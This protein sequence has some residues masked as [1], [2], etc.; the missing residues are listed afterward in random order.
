MNDLAT[1]RPELAAEWHPTKNGNLTP[2]D[3]L[4]GSHKAVFW[5]C[6]KGHTWNMVVA[7]RTQGNGCTVCSG[8]FFVRG[9]N[10]LATTNP[11]LAAQWHP[12]KNG[13][14]T[15]SD[16]VTVSSKKFWWLCS[17][18]HSWEAKLAKRHTGQG[19]PICSNNRVVVGVNDLATTNPELAAQWHP[20]K[21]GDLKP[22][23]V[24]AG[25]SKHIWWKCSKG[26]EWRMNGNGRMS[27][28]GCPVCA[29]KLLVVGVNDLATTNPELAAQWH[30]TKNGDLK[31]ADVV[32]GTAKRI[33]WQCPKGHEWQ[34]IVVSRKIG[35]GCPVCENLKVVVGVNDL[36]TTNPEL[37]AEWHPTKN[38]TLDMAT[39]SAGARKTVW[40]LCENGH[41]WKAALFK[42]STGQGCPT[43]ATFGFDPNK[44][45]ILYFIANKEL[46]ARKVGITNTGSTRLYEFG[47]AGWQQ[48]FLYETANGH[49]VR[50]VENAMFAWLRK[51]H[52]LPQHLAAEDMKRT[53]GATETFSEEGPSDLEVIERIKAEFARLTVSK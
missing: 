40:W 27:G 53:Q 12:T 10:D 48:L 35:T 23:D 37:A 42:R 52:Q 20:T 47:K 30:P 38:G 32:A 29:N 19:C 1:T 51:E 22:T 45:A 50:T 43:C 26:H 25:T 9:V 33:W 28:T 18:G 21:N 13:D 41:E 7:S 44:P 14:L 5:L 6:S 8:R 36:A 31:P 39:V 49:D 15:P 17:Q 46:A 34:S 16:V 3:V 2:M 11:E 4:S 24:V